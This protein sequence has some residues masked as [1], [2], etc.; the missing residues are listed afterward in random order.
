MSRFNV[1]CLVLQLATSCVLT[2]ASL[3][4][5][6]QEPAKVDQGIDIKPLC[7][8]QPI[9]VALVDGYG[10]D[11][12]R[13]TTVAELKDEASA[14]DN[15]TIAGYTDAGGNRQAYNAAINGYAAQGYE[16]ILAFTDFGEAAIPAYRRA[17][18][19]GTTMV[20]YFNQLSGRPGFDYAVNPYQD[21]YAI[22]QTY[23]QWMAKA[24]DGQG[25]VLMLGGPA[26]ATS[27]SIFLKGFKKGLA[28][29]PGLKLLDQ[30][31]IATNWNP[32]DA[33]KAA[34]GLIAKYGDRIDGIA[35]DFGVTAL[36][37]A[38]AFQQSGTRMPALATVASNNELNC[39]YRQSVKNGNGWKYL[40]LDGTTA[41]IRFAL[42]QAL[43]AHNHVDIDEPLGVVPYVYADSTTNTMPAC[44]KSA[45]P[46]ADLS[47]LLPENKL[48][49]LFSQ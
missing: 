40:A 30:N 36:A 18:G 2:M 26:G 31:F 1:R 23:A 37:T 47:S 8:S 28:A 13:K 46:D 4:A 12:W 21:S 34:A 32:A 11:T 17:N 15:L 14:C 27:S 10:G 45:P 49:A 6:A 22:G 25:N 41:D 29:H 42:R 33:Q 5:V 24:L 7:G 44:S 38:K 16:I 3:T 43:A 9:R 48:E 19:N 39:L 20:P 35:S